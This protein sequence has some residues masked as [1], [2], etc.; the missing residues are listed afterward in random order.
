MGRGRDWRAGGKRRRVTFHRH[1]LQDAELLEDGDEEH[2]DHRHGAKLHP[3]D[4]HGW[5]A[6]VG[7]HASRRA[8]RGPLSSPGNRR[9][10]VRLGSRGEPAG[11]LPQPHIF[12][13][14]PPRGS[15]RAGKCLLQVCP[16]G[17]GGCGAE[18]RGKGPA[19]P[20]RVSPRL[21]V[22]KDEP[23]R[24]PNFQNLAHETSPP[25]AAVASAPRS[26]RSG[27]GAAE[28][29]IATGS[30]ASSSQPQKSEPQ[31]WA[32][33]RGQPEAFPRGIPRAP[34][35]LGDGEQRVPRVRA[36]P[37]SAMPLATRAAIKDQPPPCE[38][39]G[40]EEEE[41]IRVLQVSPVP[42]WQGSPGCRMR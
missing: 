32:G 31:P 18:R 22:M 35:C 6:Q 9:D 7:G 10:A 12:H 25:A 24:R 1:G 13:V 8:P 5:A 37:P 20:S 40:V 39:E 34:Q 38:E 11:A 2:D 14:L 3:L 41:E 23:R 30:P 19:A 17:Q 36:S 27:A 42:L 28:D 33:G 21:W 26:S 29:V 16:I 4:R 15:S